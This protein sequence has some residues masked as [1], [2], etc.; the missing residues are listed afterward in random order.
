MASTLTFVRDSNA[1]EIRTLIFPD[2]IGAF[3]QQG[4]DV[5]CEAGL[6]A[7][8][9]ITDEVF[10]CAGA[11]ILPSGEAWTN[12]NIIAKYKPPTPVDVARMPPGCTF[13]SYLHLEDNPPL[14]DALCRQ[15]IRALAFEFI[16]E[17]KGHFPV[18]RG[19]SEIA[20]KM[21]VIYGAYHLQSHLG[22]SG[23]FLPAIPDVESANV[24][25]IGY[26]NSGGA[27]AR[28]AAELGANVTVLG[29][30]M[31]RLRAFAAS[32]PANV[33]CITYSADILRKLLPRMDLVIGAILISTYDTEPVITTDMVKSM[34]KGSMIVDVTCGYGPGYLETFDRQSTL[35]EPVYERHGILHCKIDKLPGGVPVSSARALSGL[36][37][38]YLVR[39]A[40]APVN[41]NIP[42]E[43]LAAAIVTDN[44]RIT[45]SHVAKLLGK[46]PARQEG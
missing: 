41:E 38:P 28:T 15:R 1:A 11:Q 14:A 45:H 30:D 29:R 25:V 42:D 2:Q 35:E 26:G 27:A 46:H 3:V 44:G 7:G 6:G 33:T 5:V 16:E 34:R 43:A 13:A 21:A 32:M 9:G 40:N 39:L 22:G 10:A 37:L 17:P 4:I 8:Y 18:T 12:A 20:G 24:L 23:V 19:H 36:C 31:S